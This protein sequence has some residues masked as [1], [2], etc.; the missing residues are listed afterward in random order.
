MS[1]R[2]MKTKLI[3]CDNSMQCEYMEEK[4][5]KLVKIETQFTKIIV[6]N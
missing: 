4:G 3:R 5:D 1:W 2:L 6:Y